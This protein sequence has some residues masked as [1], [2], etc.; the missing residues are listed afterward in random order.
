LGHKRKG[1]QIL[2]QNNRAWGRKGKG[3]KYYARTT[4]LGAG[5]KKGSENSART[6]KL[7]AGNKRGGGNYVKNGITGCHRHNR[8][9]VTDMHQVKSYYNRKACD[10]ADNKKY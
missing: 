6:R 4:E 2:R 3:V 1:G 10:N 5:K 7:E 9:Q 8:L